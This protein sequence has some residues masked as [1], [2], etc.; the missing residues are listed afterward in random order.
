MELERRSVFYWADELDKDASL[1]ILS[2]TNDKS[3]NPTQAHKIAKKLTDINYDFIL[4]EIETDHKF[5]G[6]NKELN[7][8]IA[9][10]FNGKL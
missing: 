9:N 7:N 2:G 6:K 10:W 1:L 8:L 5:S 4:K 3:V